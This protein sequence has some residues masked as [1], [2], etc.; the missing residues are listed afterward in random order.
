MVRIRPAIAL[1]LSLTLAC[2]GGFSGMQSAWADPVSP[3]RALV[4]QATMEEG[5][6]LSDESAAVPLAELLAEEAP[7]EVDEAAEGT[8]YAEGEVLVVL[9]PEAASSEV[10][11]RFDEAGVAPIEPLDEPAIGG[12]SAVAVTVEDGASVAQKVDELMEA[13]EV[14]YAQPNYLYSFEYVPNDPVFQESESRWWHLEDIDAFRAWDSAKANK[15]VRVATIDSGVKTDHQDLKNNLNLA[16]AYNTFTNQTGRD[17]AE[18][19]YGHGTHVAGIIAAEADNGTGV[20][21]SSFNAEVIPIN[22]VHPSGQYAGKST[23]ADFIEALDYI[24]DFNNRELNDIRVVNIS[25]GGYAYD[26]A[27]ATSVSV[28]TDRGI[29]IVA[30]GGNEGD[31]PQGT[32]PSYPADLR[33]VVSVTWYDASGTIDKRSDYG[34]GKTIAAPGTN[35]YSTLYSGVGSYGMKSGSSMASPVVAGV[36]AL[37]FA[38]NPDLSGSEVRQALYDTATDAGALGWDQYYGHGKVNAY[39]AVTRAIA[40][41]SGQPPENPDPPQPTPLTS[42][43]LSGADRVATSVAIAREAYPSGPGGVIIVRSDNFPDALAASSLSGALGYPILMSDSGSLSSA[44]SSYLRSTPTVKQAVLIGDRN[45]LSSRV[46]TSVSGL[47]SSCVRIGGTDRFDTAARLRSTVSQLGAGATTAVIARSD[48]YPD[49]LSISPYCAASYAGLFLI[50]PGTAPSKAMLKELAAYERVIIVGSTDSV[51]GKVESSLKG[52]SLEVVRLAGGVG[53]A[54]S[55]DR[56]GTS[57]AIANWT[58]SQSGKGFSYNNAAC[59]T[60]KKF[61]DAL[62]GGPLCASKRSVLLLVDSGSYSA[63]DAAASS[64]QVNHVYWLGSTDTLNSSLR[65]AVLSRLG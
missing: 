56:Y 24:L 36:C 45:S 15:A 44:V 65:A 22:V 39:G 52:S 30:A 14:A 20:A 6:A 31:K 3:D 48:N 9:A 27:L 40:L 10:E 13:E 60:G 25:M 62:A 18:D 29:V 42:T 4:E 58:V 50:A 35:I 17:A 7:A 54:Y 26:Q 23:T 51:S 19:R 34:P 12:Q 38:A 41:G 55:N 8:A 57:A 33:D 61:P 37:M 63:V 1:L 2:W 59:A 16:S 21:G 64:G 47:V 11:Q 28:A 32:Q 49:A 5:G 53:N 46:Q 43:E